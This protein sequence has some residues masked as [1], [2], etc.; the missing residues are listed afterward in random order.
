MP[1]HGRQAKKN[2]P[3]DGFFGILVEAAG[4]SNLH[5]LFRKSLILLAFYSGMAQPCARLGVR[6]WGIYSVMIT[7]TDSPFSTRT[8]FHRS[9]PCVDM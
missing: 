4:I 9:P 2:R 6:T 1:I 3:L 5:E 8:I 7:S